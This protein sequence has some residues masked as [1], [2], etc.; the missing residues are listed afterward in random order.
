[1]IEEAVRY[2]RD[3]EIWIYAGLG[4]VAVYA[5]VKFFLS[6][7]ELRRAAF[8]MEREIA[9]ERLNQA[10][11][12]I[13]LLLAMAVAEFSL[14]TFV[15]PTIPGANPIP[16]P[17]LDLLATPTATLSSP[18]GEALQL[19]VTLASTPSQLGGKGCIPGEVMIT[20][21][22]DGDTISG[23]V[24]LHGTADTPNFGFYKYEIARPGDSVWLSIN[25]GESAVRD[26]VLGE[27]VTTVLPPGDYLLRL[28][29]VDNQGK[30]LPP[31][32]IQVRVVVAP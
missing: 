31:C 17:T 6:W 13:V 19:I 22:K 21:P 10:A 20:I 26:G 23:V 5:F 29:V 7:E 24:V 27:W 11:I 16:S 12:L 15:A 9:Q 2:F 3:Y 18:G 14:V 4:V 1:M 30:F 32:V 25:A 8:G 28:V